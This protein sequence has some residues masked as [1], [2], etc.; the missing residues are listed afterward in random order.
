MRRLMLAS[1]AFALLGLSP[2]SAS[3]NP[4]GHAAVG[5]RAPAITLVDG[6]WE[7]E[8][9]N[10]APDRY[11]QLQRSQRNRYNALQARIDERHRRYHYD[12]YDQ[13]DSRDLREQHQI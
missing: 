5:A 7:R 1:A 13:R 10:D 11:W 6:W 9:H 8:N 4:M 12:Q 2:I 3:A